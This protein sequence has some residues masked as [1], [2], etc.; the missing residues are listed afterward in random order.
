MRSTVDVVHVWMTVGD[1]AVRTVNF[2][3]GQR[4]APNLSAK[5]KN[6]LM[7]RCNMTVM[8]L[9]KQRTASDDNFCAWA[10]EIPWV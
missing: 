1:C 8:S 9:P 2:N 6:G 5:L 3:P 4:W 7:D 10:P